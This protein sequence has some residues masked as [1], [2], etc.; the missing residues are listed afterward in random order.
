MNVKLTREQFSALVWELRAVSIFF[1]RPL[2]VEVDGM[3][4]EVGM[5]LGGLSWTFLSRGQ[6][7]EVGCGQ[8]CTNTHRTAW[9]YY[10]SEEQYATEHAVPIDVR[11]ND[12]LTRF[13]VWQQED[14]LRCKQL[15]DDNLCSIHDKGQPLHC[16][17]YPQTWVYPHGGKYFLSRRLP[18][19]NW[20]WPKCP[21][22]VWDVKASEESYLQNLR[23]LHHFQEFCRQS[24]DQRAYDLAF[25]VTSFVIDRP[26][27]TKLP[28][29]I[30]FPLTQ[31]VK[32]TPRLKV[33][34]ELAMLH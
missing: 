16:Q 32:N 18:P 26:D 9:F 23:V 3:R 8:C 6:D 20:R 33:R 12:Q 4:E 24:N 5:G 14:T 2:T 19:R 13:F 15:T 31:V 29:S 11:V 34:H 10:S 27:P 28:A 1:D 17:M 30:H 25:D 21:I 22:P 7:C